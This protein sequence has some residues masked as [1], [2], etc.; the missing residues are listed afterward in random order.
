[1]NNKIKL[2]Y[3][4]SIQEI[5]KAELEENINNAVDYWTDMDDAM[6]DNITDEVF[7]ANSKVVTFTAEQKR[8]L[9]NKAS[10]AASIVCAGDPELW[11]SAY[12]AMLD[13]VVE[14]KAEAIYEE[15]ND[16]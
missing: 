12:H 16:L 9:V 14:D 15:A 4:T 3:A 6:M 10:E 8:A 11:L 7:A 2:A 5:R 13:V 1:M